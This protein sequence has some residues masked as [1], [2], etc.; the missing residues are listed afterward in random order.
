MAAAVL[1]FCQ[2]RILCGCFLFRLP[3][4][5]GTC[6]GD[7]RTIRCCSR[8]CGHRVTFGVDGCLGLAPFRNI[9]MASASFGAPRLLSLL[10]L[11]SLR[12]PSGAGIV[13]R[14]RLFVWQSFSPVFVSNCP[15]GPGLPIADR[16]S[17]V[18][19]RLRIARRRRVWIVHLVQQLRHGRNAI[20]S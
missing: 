6:A 16:L 20:P 11:L 3:S 1:L 2:F 14:L 10:G 18:R 13:I 15:A 12:R 8:R 9:R 4:S 5:G 7:R 17:R 19:S